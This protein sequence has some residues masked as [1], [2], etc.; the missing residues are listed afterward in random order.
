MSR[1]HHRI[2]W[3]T[4]G[5][6][7][8]SLLAAAGSARAATVV[9]P[10]TPIFKGVDYSVSTNLPGSGNFPR[11][12]VVHAFRVD[13]TDPDVRLFATPPHPDPV[14]GRAET[15][16]QTTSGFLTQ[17]NLQVALS[18]NFFG[19]GDYYLPAGTAME[20]R[21]LLI[22]EG[23]VVS[24]QEGSSNSAA[25]LFDAANEATFIQ[26]NWPVAD[27]TG[28]QTAVSG[29]RA[30]LAGG[31]NLETDVNSRDLDPRTAYGLSEDRRFLYLMGID[32][33]Q[34]GYSDG[35]NYYETAAWL[36]LLGAYEG[37]NMDGGG[38]TLLVMED[39]TGRPIRL[40]KSNA[41]ADSGR[42]RT[43]GAHFGVYAQ[44]VPGFINEVAVVPDDTTARVTWTTVDPSTTEVEYGPTDSLGLTTGVQ[45]DLATNHGI[46]LTGLTP[47]TDYYFRA[48]SA[49]GTERHLSP[50]FHF[51]TTNYVTTNEIFGFSHAWKHADTT[52]DLGGKD[53]TWHDFPD[54]DWNGP[55]PGLLWVDGN[56]NPDVQP[57]GTEM[58]MDP[59]TG[60]PYL[61]Y[62]FRTRFMLSDVRLG[63][64]LDF[65]CYVDDGAVFYL[66]GTEIQRLRMPAE[67]DGA[68]LATG[69]ACDGNA[70]TDCVDA[71]SVPL[72]TLDNLVEGENL[73]A[74]EVHNYHPR[75]PDITFG[76]RLNRITPLPRNARLTIRQEAGGLSLSWDAAGFTLETAA[77]SEGPWSE[78]EGNPGSPV[79]L[80]PVGSQRYYRLRH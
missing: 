1:P 31:R 45:P 40:S 56:N 33:R 60:F 48:A 26:R 75:S 55:G 24:A 61:S 12:Q 76:V 35:A 13:L 11:R 80:E 36:L 39:S 77:S 41:V 53:W 68:T 46:Q 65:A 8:L 23:A 34:P 10:W 25:L 64:S 7:V 17:N 4:G 30:L 38:S 78:V 50:I 72:D 44:P 29:N 15:A 69:Y 70:T 66:N 32:G 27:L 62:Y 73:L 37:A 49:T 58:A 16:G 51:V 2:L 71:F 63:G 9:G 47:W 28:V 5:R 79:D 14:A 21:G 19:P 43:L 20:V 18:A 74:V 42:E 3:Q 52:F 22:S 54:F 67:W 6:L 57:K 59:G